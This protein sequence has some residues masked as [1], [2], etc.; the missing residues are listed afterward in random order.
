MPHGIRC[1][2]DGA[3]ARGDHPVRWPVER[4]RQRRSRWIQ[5]FEQ[6]VPVF[7]ICYG[8]RRWPRRSGRGPRTPAASEY[9]R[10]PLEVL[11]TESRLLEHQP[12]E[13]SV[14][15]SRRCCDR[16]HLRASL[17]SSTPG[18]PVASFER[19]SPLRRRS[20]PPEVI[21]TE[22][23]QQL[24]QQFLHGIAGLDGEWTTAKRHR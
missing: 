12:P 8:S 24:L 19:R 16:L 18:A 23:G 17:S 14:W 7:G 15:M 22:G 11:R 13:S 2:V 20:V 5:L 9:G 3:Q 21:H 6:G 4:L 1:R 10:T